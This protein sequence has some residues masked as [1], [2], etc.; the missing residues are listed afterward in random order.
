M[1]GTLRCVCGHL[2]SLQPTAG[3]TAGPSPGPFPTREGG[4]TP[5]REPRT[6]SNTWVGVLHMF[7]SLVYVANFM[8]M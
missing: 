4:A 3:D 1:R 5:A 6:E 2:I 8:G 7:S